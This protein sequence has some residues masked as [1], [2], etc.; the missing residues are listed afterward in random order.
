MRLNV[1]KCKLIHFATKKHDQQPISLANTQLEAVSAY[2]YLGIDITDKL[3]SDKYWERLSSSIRQNIALLKQLK[4]SWLG[5]QILAS[6]GRS[7]WPSKRC[8]G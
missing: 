4:S 8:M 2:T 6:P 7:R 1:S 3:D 5:Q